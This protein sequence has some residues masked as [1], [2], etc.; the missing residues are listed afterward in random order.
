M[1][2]IAESLENQHIQ[3]DKI[4][5]LNGMHE[6]ID[7][8]PRKKK[9][10]KSKTDPTGDEDLVAQVSQ[11]ENQIED[12]TINERNEGELEEITNGDEP[13]PDTKEPFGAGFTIL[14]EF[15]VD[16][17]KKIHRVLPI[18]LAKPS[19]ISCDLKNNKIPIS[20]L[21]GLEKFLVDAL[22]RNKINHLFPGK[23]KFIFYF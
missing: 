7:A 3:Q 9:K 19:I 2:H 17:S 1:E 20:E 12:E 14:E 15:K 4:P 21:K 13:Q 23:L 6:D 22:K 5:E 8:P 16:R 18:W 10:K 11:E